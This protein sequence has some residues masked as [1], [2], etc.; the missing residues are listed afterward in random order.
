MEPLSPEQAQRIA[1][2]VQTAMKVGQCDATHYD[3]NQYP[4]A[5]A[6]LM[7]VLASQCWPHLGA[8]AFPSSIPPQPTQETTQ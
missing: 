1:Q 6:Y 5:W 4:S 8:D 7:G 3:G 2:S